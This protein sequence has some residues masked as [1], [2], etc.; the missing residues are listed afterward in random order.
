MT[1]NRPAPT[2]EALTVSTDARDRLIVAAL[3]VAESAWLFALLGIIGLGMGNGGSALGW[4]AVLALLATGAG[5]AR[6]LSS[7]MFGGALPYV[8][9]IIAG[10]SAIY[11]TMATQVGTSD[12][13][14]NLGWPMAASGS[15]DV[16]GANFRATFGTVAAVLLWWRGG[17]LG[18]SEEPTESLNRS[19]KFGMVLMALAVLVDVNSEAVLHTFGALFAFFAGSLAGLGVARLG[20][21]AGGERGAMI[22]LRV[23]AGTVAGVLAV[24]A[25]FSLIRREFLEAVRAPVSEVLGWM[26]TALFYV[27]ILP[28][29][30]VING[31]VGLV[32]GLFSGDGP[33]RELIPTGE[34]L[35]EQFLQRE[36][37]PTPSYVTALEWVLL[38]VVI[39][40]AL[41]V[42]VFALRRRGRR[43]PA[44][45]EGVRESVLGES[46]PMLDAAN[47]LFGLLPSALRRRRAGSRVTLPSGPPDVVEA[48]RSYYR[49]LL[50]AG[51]RGGDRPSS[52][53]PAEYR[54]RLAQLV[55]G[56]LADASTEA[57]NAAF[58]GGHEP[59]GDDLAQIRAELDR[60][61]APDLPGSPD[62]PKP[63]DY[64]N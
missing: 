45:I 32:L 55:P 56:H 41:Y 31:L 13:F 62:P 9:Q 47:M 19:F 44:Q 1:T 14:W 7:S 36:A 18:S 35:G 11:L 22:W 57:F 16:A 30:W 54:A 61:G 46:D 4:L 26:G 63:P 59:D 10:V 49:L 64:G 20:H 51:G 17:T 50:H 38:A 58:Y 15:S 3:V 21:G 25:A 37:G 34:S 29:A 43:R 24:G 33:T 28:V 42:I 5:V 39:A 52:T 6:V 8:L 40:V 27:V 60:L 2:H 48:M 12:A 23:V 53:T